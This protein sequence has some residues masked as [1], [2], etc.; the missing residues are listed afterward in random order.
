MQCMSGIMDNQK[1][2]TVNCAN[3]LLCIL[4]IFI[5]AIEA[6]FGYEYAKVLVVC[7]LCSLVFLFAIL[8]CYDPW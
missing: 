5:W 1:K 3:I 8:L 7:G 2:F 6:V 4:L